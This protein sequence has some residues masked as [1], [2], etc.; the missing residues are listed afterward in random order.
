MHRESISGIRDLLQQNSL[1]LER[2]AR[3]TRSLRDTHPNV[4]VRSS[5]LIDDVSE[6]GS[7]ADTVQ[8][9]VSDSTFVFDDLIVD[10]KVYRR[11][12]AHATSKTKL[13]LNH[14]K[15]DIGEGSGETA[16]IERG[17]AK[18]HW[19]HIIQDFCLSI[20]EDSDY[21]EAK[22]GLKERSDFK[23]F[24]EELQAVKA[25]F[26]ILD[27]DERRY[28]LETMANANKVEISDTRG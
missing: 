5:I 3:R 19:A 27:L 6:I 18:R 8:T 21:Q 10:S 1:L 2:V 22:R 20:E 25:W 17:G 15:D 12:L 26:L 28:S 4:V 9:G 14:E 24:E 11:A 7:M 16:D 23:E 13:S